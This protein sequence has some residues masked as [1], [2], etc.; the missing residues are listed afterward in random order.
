MNDHRSIAQRSID[1]RA[2]LG[3]KF[4]RE[5]SGLLRNYFL[6]SHTV[7]AYGRKKVFF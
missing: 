5:Y 2:D 1:H 4:V 6:H 3:A 7:T